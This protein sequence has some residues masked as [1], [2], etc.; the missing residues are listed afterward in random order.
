MSIA[1]YFAGKGVTTVEQQ[2]AALEGILDL[3]RQPGFVHDVFVNCDCR[4]ERSNLFEDMCTL[5]SK[6]AYPVTKG[7]TGPSQFICQESLLAILQVGLGE[8][9]GGVLEGLGEG[10]GMMVR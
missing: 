7:S 3:C 6:T 4:L 8:E 10:E 2:E 1:C 9:G 5:I